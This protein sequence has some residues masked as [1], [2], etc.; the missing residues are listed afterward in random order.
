MV[1]RLPL[2]EVLG[3]TPWRQRLRKTVFAVRGDALTPPS[4]FDHTSLRILQ[5]R[6]AAAI[7]RG[8]RPFGDAVPIYNLFNRTPTPIARGWSVRKTTVRDFRGG[9]LTYDSHNG[10]DF[11]TPV[12]TR[13][14][15]AAP[16]VVRRISSEFN[17]GGLKVFVDHGDNL[18]TTYNH[19]ARALVAVGERV[20][21]GQ[22]LALSGYSG[23]DGVA[24]FPW[25]IPHVHFNVWLGGE[26]VDPFAPEGET[27]L[28]LHGNWPEP[29]R[30]PPDDAIPS[31]RWD[32][33]ALARAREACL[34]E[35]SRR[36]IDAARD[37]DGRGMTLLFHASYYPTRF[38]DRPFLY[39]ARIARAPRLTLPFLADDYDGVFFP[40]A[41]APAMAPVDTT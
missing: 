19:L 34:S 28:W 14:V 33:D 15:A 17:R 30:G 38:R 22:V 1:D 18:V 23:I 39:R 4:R 27:P 41:T 9:T 37:D 12:G 20:S 40:G 7:W 35:A 3:L 31:T 2:T 24:T 25:G 21:R 36:E 13:V 11:A 6:L 10:T 26:Y 5:P 29:H 32:L 16:G 8:R